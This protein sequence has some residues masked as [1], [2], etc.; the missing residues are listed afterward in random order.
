MPVQ[1]I[2]DLHLKIDRSF[3]VQPDMDVQTDF[4][5]A[6]GFSQNDGI[7]DLNGMN[8]CLF[9]V[10]QGTDQPAQDLVVGLEDGAEHVIVGHVVRNSAMC[11]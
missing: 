11:V 9:E 5:V 4:L 2:D 10:K 1:M 6:Y 3:V 8:F 7:C